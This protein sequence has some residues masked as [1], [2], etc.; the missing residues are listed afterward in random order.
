LCTAYNED[1]LLMYCLVWETVQIQIQMQYIKFEKA[2]TVLFFVL[3][4][5]SMLCLSTVLSCVG[6]SANTKSN[7][8]HKREK[9]VTMLCF[10][11]PAISTLCLC[12]VLCGKLCKCKVKGSTP[13]QKRL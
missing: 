7:A 13:N 12:T 6:G 9:A 10:V 2:V 1:S 11:L 5:I 3:P 4:K 8:V